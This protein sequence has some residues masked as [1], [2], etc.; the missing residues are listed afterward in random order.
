[1]DRN[2]VT[3]RMESF[4]GDINGIE[5]YEA[6]AHDREVAVSLAE[7]EDRLGI[8]FT[9]AFTAAHRYGLVAFEGNAGANV[10]ELHFKPREEVFDG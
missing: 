4:A 10:A 1:M 7:S 8:D 2:D 5:E 6:T 3:T 9:D